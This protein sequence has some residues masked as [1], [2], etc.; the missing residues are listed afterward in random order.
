MRVQTTKKRQRGGECHEGNARPPPPDGTRSH[1]SER[2][3]AGSNNSDG[4]DK[5]GVMNDMS[6]TIPN[7]SRPGYVVAARMAVGRFGA[8]QGM[9]RNR[10]RP[11]TRT[12]P[13]WLERGEHVDR[14]HDKV[15]VMSS[16]CRRPRSRSSKRDR[17][18]KKKGVWSRAHRV[19]T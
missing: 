7:S 5:I 11:T 6:G 3:R 17:R 18:D 8:A 9:S 14:R 10:Q 2:F 15:G 13:T 12:N 4:Q 1:T 19:R 16:T